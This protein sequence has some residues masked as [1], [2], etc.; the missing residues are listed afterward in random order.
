MDI[1]EIRRK[2]MEELSKKLQEREMIE[3][4]IREMERVAAL[5]LDDKAY[6]RLNNIKLV[7]EELAMKITTLLYQLYTSGRIRR[8]ID[9]NAFKQLISQLLPQK[10]ESKIIR[11]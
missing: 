2:K 6:E 4:Q 5:I 1:E 9:D 8:K 11:K 3:N 10:R 7:N